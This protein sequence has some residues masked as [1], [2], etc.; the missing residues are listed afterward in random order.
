VLLDP[1]HRMSSVSRICQLA[2]CS[3]D[4]YYTAMRRPDFAAHYRHC[5]LEI[6]KHQAGQLVNIGFREARKGGSRGFGYWKELMKMCGFFEDDKFNVE[7]KGEML[8]RFVDPASDEK[9]SVLDDD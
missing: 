7:S 9:D 8:I 3:R 5:C 6:I 2:H 4:F 1:F